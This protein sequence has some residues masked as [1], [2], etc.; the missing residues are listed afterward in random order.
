[1]RN[2]TPERVDSTQMGC[3]EPPASADETAQILDD[4]IRALE[5][6]RAR[7]EQ[8]ILELRTEQ[9]HL[10]ER[11]VGLEE[12]NSFLTTL[13]VAC[14]RLHSTLDRAEVLQT[15]REIIANLL[16]CEEYV[17]FR[18]GSD[19]SLHRVD[20]SGVARPRADGACRRDGRGLPGG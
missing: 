1:M 11:Y 6:S 16:G 14:Q 15:V 2:R 18:L 10:L 13:Y 19:G 5:A 4:R 17:L 8:K 3:P 7:L 20:S 12:Q 9:Q